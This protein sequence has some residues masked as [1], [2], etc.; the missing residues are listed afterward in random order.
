MFIHA[1]KI[2][3][4][5]FIADINKQNSFTQNVLNLGDSNKYRYCYLKDSNES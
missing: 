3:P 2:K 4:G 5:P 1:F